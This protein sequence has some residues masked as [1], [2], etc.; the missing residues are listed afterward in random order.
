MIE[1]AKKLSLGIPHVRVDFYSIVKNFYFGE[2]TFYHGGG[3]EKFSP[4]TLNRI[5]GDKIDLKGI[6]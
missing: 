3:F 5:L 2:L 6:F 4:N 1:C